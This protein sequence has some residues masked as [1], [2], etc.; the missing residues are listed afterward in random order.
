MIKQLSTPLPGANGLAIFGAGA[1]AREV[2]WLARECWGDD[3]KLTF[4]VDRSDL[5]GPAQNDIPV[6]HLVDFANKFF[7][8]LVTVAIGD[9]VLR[10]ECV[11]KCSAAGLQFASLVHP[12]IEVSRWVSIGTGTIVCAGAILTTNITIG[13]HVHINVGCTVSHDAN[14]ADFVTLSPGVHISGWVKV[15]RRAFLGTGAVVINGSSERPIII[16]DDAVIGAGA[17][18]IQDV[19][20]GTTVVGVPAARRLR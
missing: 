5:V 18:V 2:A 17:C 7:G 6:M 14:L 12:R 13:R 8:T 11:R 16:G 20:P 15:G 10:E 9:A 19:A 4:L 3:L 1:S